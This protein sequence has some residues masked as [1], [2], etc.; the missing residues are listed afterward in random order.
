M[1]QCHMFRNRPCVGQYGG[2]ELA[3]D[4]LRDSFQ[5]TD[6]EAIF[7]I[8]PNNASIRTITF[9]LDTSRNYAVRVF[10]PD[11]NY[12]IKYLFCFLTEPDL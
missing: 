2:I 7:L 8:D 10:F 1:K 11:A 12:I 9:S 4:F 6:S 3:I 5:N